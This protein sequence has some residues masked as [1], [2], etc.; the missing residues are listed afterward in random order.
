MFQHDT[1]LYRDGEARL[2]KAGEAYPGEGWADTPDP[3]RA[4]PQL[5]HDGNGTPGGS[6]PKRKRK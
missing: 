3:A 1:W 2:F 4:K 5:D 6:T